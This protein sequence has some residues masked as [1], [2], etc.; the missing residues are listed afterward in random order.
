[1]KSGYEALRR[2]KDAAVKYLSDTLQEL[3]AKQTRNAPTLEECVKCEPSGGIPHH[4]CRTPGFAV[5]ENIELIYSKYVDHLWEDVPF[6]N[7][8]FSIEQFI[9]FYFTQV[10]FTSII[11]GDKILLKLFFPKIIDQ[12]MIENN[13]T[14]SIILFGPRIMPDADLDLIVS[15]PEDFHR[16]YTK[17]NYDRPTNQGCIFLKRE[18]NFQIEHSKGCLLHVDGSAKRITTKPID[19]V[20]FNCKLNDSDKEKGEKIILYFGELLLEFGTIL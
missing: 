13:T 20:S 7:K 8:N 15:F 10:I 11:A 1:L 19:C 6:G 17:R 9:Q 18:K 12:L 14:G 2:N 16:F 5:Y 3:L 4:C